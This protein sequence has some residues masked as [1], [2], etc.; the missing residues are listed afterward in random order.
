MFESIKKVLAKEYFHETPDV[1]RSKDFDRA[2]KSFI[3]GKIKP[4]GLEIV[5][6]RGCGYCESS[7]FVT[8]NK[9]HYV[10]FNSGDYRFDGMCNDIYH[11]VLIRTAENEKDY[12]GGT[13]HFVELK[14][15][16]AEINKLIQTPHI[17]H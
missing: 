17:R 10:Y 9:G 11:N 14:D 3:R 5:R 16:G 15:I 12:H 6:D 8:D 7:G 4:Y 13:N 1:P 2:Y